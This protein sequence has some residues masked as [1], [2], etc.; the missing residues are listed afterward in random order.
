M[1]QISS[2]KSFNSY[3]VFWTILHPDTILQKFIGNG[4]KKIINYR[5][6]CQAFEL[7]LKICKILCLFADQ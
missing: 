2:Y 4:S 7:N 5:N 3:H 1:F 6:I